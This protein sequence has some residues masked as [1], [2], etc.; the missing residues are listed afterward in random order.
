VEAIEFE[1]AG[2]PVLRSEVV[3][4]G[5][6]GAGHGP[7]TG[8]PVY[9]VQAQGVAQLVRAPREPIKRPGYPGAPGPAA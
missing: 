5:V 2:G 9:V 1:A 3:V 7:N 6:L 8:V 4:T